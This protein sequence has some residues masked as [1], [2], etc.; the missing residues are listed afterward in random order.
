MSI[1]EHKSP[2][3]R[4]H[5]AGDPPPSSFLLST[6]LPL[7]APKTQPL[8]FPVSFTPSTGTLLT[9][10]LFARAGCS[11]TTD[12]RNIAGQLASSRVHIASLIPRAGCL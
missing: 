6:L 8:Y 5:T 2:P 12:S 1:D 10:F 4:K 3:S 7:P 11:I 9:S